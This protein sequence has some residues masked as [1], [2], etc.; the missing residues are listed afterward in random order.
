MPTN[1]ALYTQIDEQITDK[2]TAA[3]ISPTNVGENI[4]AAIGYTDQEVAD[5]KA[6][7]ARPYKVYS[8]KINQSGTAAPIPIIYENTLG[9]NPV[10][11]RFSAGS[12]TLTLSNA[13]VNNKCWEICNQVDSNTFI[14]IQRQT[15]NIYQIN[16]TQ[17][18][19]SSDD[20]IQNVSIEIRVYN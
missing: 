18:G 4:K 10:L 14:S 13:F 3:S 2:T 17:G 1:V 20:L 6:E 12:Y 11:A 7:V 8:A 9:G 16:S 15:T 19:V 5:S